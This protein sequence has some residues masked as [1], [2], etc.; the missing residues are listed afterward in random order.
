MFELSESSWWHCLARFGTT[1]RRCLVEKVC[2]W[3]RDRPLGIVAYLHPCL[4]SAL[5]LWIPIWSV[6][7]CSSLHT[8]P[9][10]YH[11]RLFPCKTISHDIPCLLKIFLSGYYIMVINIQRKCNKLFLFTVH[12][13]CICINR[14][15]CHI[16]FFILFLFFSALGIKLRAS[17]V[18]QTLCQWPIPLSLC[19]GFI[20]CILL[21]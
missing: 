14:D 4:L 1:R 15:A 5:W 9:V 8:F 19:F 13:I 21:T 12:N 20:F 10:C 2:H 6:S 11:D 7:L 17:H 3:G 18:K 16:N